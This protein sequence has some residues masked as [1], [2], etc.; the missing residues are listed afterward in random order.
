VRL[1]GK[2][3]I[4][5]GAGKGI[6]V[7]I[8]RCLAEAGANVVV[9]ALHEESAARVADQVKA[10]GRESL[11]VAADVTTKEGAAKVVQRT[12]D[13]FGKIDI[14]VNNFGAHT[15]AFYTGSSPTF[16]DQEIKEWDDDYQYNLKSQV[17]MCLEVVP[18]FIEQQSGKIINISSIAGRMTLP[19]QMPYGAFKAGSIY[20]TRTLAV[21][22]GKHNI[23][24]NCVCPGGVYSGMTE[25]FMQKA[26]DGNPDHK[27]MT[28]REYYEQRVQ[29]KIPERAP[30]PL[31][32]ELMAEDVGY[33]VVFFASEEAKNITGQSLTVDCGLV[34]Y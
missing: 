2:V 25:R 11:A 12:L 26:I 3:A 15:E 23:N 19:T 29:P 14:L 10:L 5:T 8:V 32:R 16:A 18:H 1:E 24:V 13:A 33:A 9:N 28:P 17:L 34:T 30:S 31:K 22:L 21:E 7:G 20:F 27:G 6:G 4:V